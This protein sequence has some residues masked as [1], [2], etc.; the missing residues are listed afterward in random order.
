LPV[1]DHAASPDPLDVPRTPAHNRNA[2][3]AL[4]Q[5]KIIAKF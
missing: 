1:E 4:P 2:G 5:Q 3:R